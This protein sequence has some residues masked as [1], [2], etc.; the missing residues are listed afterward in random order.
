M[1]QYWTLSYPVEYE[2]VWNYKKVNLKTM[3]KFNSTWAN[4]NKDNLFTATDDAM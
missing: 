4:V 1:K 3:V 2:I